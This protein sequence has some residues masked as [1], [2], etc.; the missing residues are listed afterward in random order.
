M[1]ETVILLQQEV[2]ELDIQDPTTANDGG[3]QSFLV[4]LQHKLDRQ[5]SELHLTD[6]DLLK[7]P[8]YAFDYKQGGWQDRPIRIFGRTLGPKLGRTLKP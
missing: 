8:R 4:S 6:E 2:K 7:I 5:T 3:Y 1:P